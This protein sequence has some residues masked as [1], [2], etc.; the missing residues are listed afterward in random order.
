MRT[1]KGEH[2]NCMSAQQ[3]K[4]C[5]SQMEALV[6]VFAQD[7]VM[8]AAWYKY[9]NSVRGVVDVKTI[10]KCLKARAR[11][12]VLFGGEHLQLRVGDLVHRLN[13][14]VPT[15]EL[16]G[17]ALATQLMHTTDCLTTNPYMGSPESDTARHNTVVTLVDRLC[18][19]YDAWQPTGLLEQ[20]FKLG[21]DKTFSR[22]AEELR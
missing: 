22:H 11:V 6:L 13:E 3:E 1:G 10:M 17:I 4:E 15:S 19:E 21:I 2:A 12:G 5:K 14:T 9:E 16:E 18:V 7:A 20:C 8:L